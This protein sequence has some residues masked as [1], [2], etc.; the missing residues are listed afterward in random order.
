MLHPGGGANSVGS[1]SCSIQQWSGLIRAVLEEDETTLG[2]R[3]FGD[4]RTSW[5]AHPELHVQTAGGDHRILHEGVVNANEIVHRTS[6]CGEEH[7]LL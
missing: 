5:A 3:E 1:G 2:R 6:Y 4:R 7:T